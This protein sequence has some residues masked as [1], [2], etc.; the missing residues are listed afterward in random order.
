MLTII[1]KIKNI[2]FIFMLLAT[3]AYAI[4]DSS[5]L[6][7]VKNLTDPAQKVANLAYVTFASATGASQLMGL[8]PAGL[9][10]VTGSGT[11]V[12]PVPGL[13]DTEQF[14]WQ[15]V[16]S[17]NG[18][19]TAQNSGDIQPYG[20]MNYSSA[21]STNL[22]DNSQDGR[23]V[24]ASDPNF[25][26]QHVSYTYFNF[27]G[28]QFIPTGLGGSGVVCPS[29]KGS[30][31]INCT[32]SLG[33]TVLNGTYYGLDKPT[34]FYIGPGD[35]AHCQVSRTYQNGPPCNGT[36]NIPSGQAK[37]MACCQGNWYCK[38]GSWQDPAL[39]TCDQC[40]CGG[41]GQPACGPGNC[42]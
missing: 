28:N 41:S 22:V 20:G 5:M 34:V 2:F 19:S 31:T 21:Y 37:V 11:R 18:W 39:T 38:T 32:N 27:P 3:Q 7:P 25:D 23:P 13:W 16:Q 40:P 1:R 26:P 14:Y 36:V 29:A 9:V 24:W 42:N 15:C 4:Q 35:T 10:L 30:V 33:Q 12:P 6:N 17:I 8:C